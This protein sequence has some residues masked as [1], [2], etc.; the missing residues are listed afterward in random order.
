M[1]KQPLRQD[2]S[3][4][5][6]LHISVI[7]LAPF[8]APLIYLLYLNVLNFHVSVSAEHLNVDLSFLRGEFVKFFMAN[9]F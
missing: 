6:S 4:L 1:Q 9:S 3:F 8:N 2:L 5:A 7:L